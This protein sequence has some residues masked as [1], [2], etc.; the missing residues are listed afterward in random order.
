MNSG[1]QR[2]SRWLNLDGALFAAGAILVAIYI[3]RIG[4]YL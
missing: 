1:V 3:A 4:P 2:S